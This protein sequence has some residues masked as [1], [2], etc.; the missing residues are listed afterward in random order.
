MD[1]QTLSDPKLTTPT[2]SDPKFRR[3]YFD[4]EDWAGTT[5]GT[6]PTKTQRYHEYARFGL[7]LVTSWV[8]AIDKNPEIYAVA[9][10]RWPYDEADF[11]RM[12]MDLSVNGSHNDLDE[13]VRRITKLYMMIAKNLDKDISEL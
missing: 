1:T 9:Y 3:D 11:R 7:D 13:I 8:L 5:D 10:E 2:P 12:Q 4:L 6:H